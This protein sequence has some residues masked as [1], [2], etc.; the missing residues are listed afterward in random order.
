M[1]T[2]PGNT[3][4]LIKQLDK[5]YPDIMETTNKD[6]FERGKSAGVIE[7]IRYLKFLQD[8]NNPNKIV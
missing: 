6:E 1:E 7:L 5:L 4:D 3:I 2:L 8:K